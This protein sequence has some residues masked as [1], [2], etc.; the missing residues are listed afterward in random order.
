LSLF[1]E[2]FQNDY[3]ICIDTVHNTPSRSCIVDPQFMA[4]R[5]NRSHRP[6][7]GH[8]QRFALLQLTQK[9]TGFQSGCGRK[10]W[11]FDLSFEPNERFMPT[12]T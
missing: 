4:A 10:R 11:C 6:R 7:V 12:L 1:A 2:Y 3:G 8:T 9:K 5:A